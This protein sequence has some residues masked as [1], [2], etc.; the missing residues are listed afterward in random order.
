MVV[1]GRF[2]PRGH[3]TQVSA[4]RHLPMA[5]R[6]RRRGFGE[7]PRI[8]LRAPL[9]LVGYADAAQALA[10]V[11]RELSAFAVIEVE[12]ERALPRERLP[13]AFRRD[14]RI[15]VHVAA[16]PSAELHDDRYPHAAAFG[17]R[18]CERTLE[19]FVEWRYDAVEDVGQK[20][21]HVLGFVA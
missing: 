10:Q 14:V 2:E 11:R 17:K 20:E 1:V 18:S 19:A 16:D 3:E 4:I 7:V 5:R 15:A 12:D 21:Q 13:N 8:K 6:Q 9:D